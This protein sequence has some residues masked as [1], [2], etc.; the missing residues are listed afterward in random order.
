MHRVQF[1]RYL[2][3]F[4]STPLPFVKIIVVYDRYKT[5]VNGA[6]SGNVDNLATLLRRIFSDVIDRT[7]TLLRRCVLP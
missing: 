1:A 5:L 7:S 3:I 2:D 4:P 6:S